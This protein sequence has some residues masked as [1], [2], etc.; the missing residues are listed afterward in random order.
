M[1][2]QEGKGIKGKEKSR[3]MIWETGKGKDSRGKKNEAIR[4]KERG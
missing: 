2:W 1:W 4:G 3:R